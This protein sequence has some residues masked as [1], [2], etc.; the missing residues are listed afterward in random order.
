MVYVATKGGILYYNPE[1]NLYIHRS[2]HDWFNEYNYQIS[3]KDKHT[4]GTLILQKYPEIRLHHLDILN[5]IPC[6][7]DITSTP[8]S[9]TT[10]ITH[11]TE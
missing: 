7:L 5:L 8:F 9:D 11:E 10:T 1:Q 6:K 3:P 4:P 2:H